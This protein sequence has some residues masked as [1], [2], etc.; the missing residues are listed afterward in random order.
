MSAHLEGNVVVPLAEAPAWQAASTLSRTCLLEISG[1][2]AGQFVRS[3]KG[4]SLTRAAGLG[5]P[6][7]I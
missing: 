1:A 2:G 6:R 5:Q 7:S 4:R 3:S